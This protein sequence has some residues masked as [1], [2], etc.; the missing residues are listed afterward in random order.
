MGLSQ[1]L[2]QYNLTSAFSPGRRRRLWWLPGHCTASR[3]H[4]PS[5]YQLTD[6]NT[7][8]GSSDARICS[9]LPSAISNPGNGDQA[10][11]V[12]VGASGRLAVPHRAGLGWGSRRAAQWSFADRTQPALRKRYHTSSDTQSQTTSNRSRQKPRRKKIIFRLKSSDQSRRD[13]F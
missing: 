8:P 7:V 6:F 1:S 3:C 4:P 12:G 2:Q 5:S 13:L 10:W 11:W 9:K